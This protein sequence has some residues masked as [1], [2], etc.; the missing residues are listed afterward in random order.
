MRIVSNIGNT[1]IRRIPGI[2][3]PTWPS[4]QRWPQNPYVAPTVPK[5]DHDKLLEE[6]KEMKRQLEEA[7]RQ[8]IANNEP[9]C[10]MEDKVVLLKKVAEIMGIDLGDVFN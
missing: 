2:W 9:D 7:K 6:L 1:W 5:E 3:P 8:D 4:P 10:E